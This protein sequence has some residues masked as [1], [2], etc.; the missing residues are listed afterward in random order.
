MLDTPHSKYG[1]DKDS[2]RYHKE[3][4]SWQ[5]GGQGWDYFSVPIHPLRIVDHTIRINNFGL[6]FALSTA[7]LKRT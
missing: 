1:L 2:F 6:D 3:S 7:H 4:W 5:S